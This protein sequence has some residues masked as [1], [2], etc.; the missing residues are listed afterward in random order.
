MRRGYQ[1]LLHTQSFDAE[2][3][4]IASL[5]ENGRLPTEPDTRRCTGSNDVP[6]VKRHKTRQVGHQILNGEDHRRGRPLLIAAPIHIQPNRQPLRIRNLVHRH[7]PRPKR[8][9]RVVRT[10]FGPLPLMFELKAALGHIVREAP[11]ASNSGI[12]YRTVI[13]GAGS[14]LEKCGCW[15]KTPRIPGA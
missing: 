14:M 3:D 12:H 9:E 5:Q 15:T 10:A 1:L 7:Q 6:R 13:V 11:G 4:T 8:S 2:R